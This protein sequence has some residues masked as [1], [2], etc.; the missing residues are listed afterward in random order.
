MDQ[1]GDQAL[2]AR[3]AV[4]V[5]TLTDTPTLPFPTE[6]ACSPIPDPASRSEPA[7][8]A[9]PPVENHWSLPPS[10][11]AQEDPDTRIL[12]LL[13]VAMKPVQAS[14]EVISSRITAI[15]KDRAW[16]PSCNYTS[17]DHLLAPPT[18]WAGR[19]DEFPNYSPSPTARD[20]DTPMSDAGDGWDDSVNASRMKTPTPLRWLNAPTR[21]TPSS[22]SSSARFMTCHPPHTRRL[23][24]SAPNLTRS[25]G[26]SPA[27]SPTCGPTSA[28]ART[29]PTPFL[30]RTTSTSSAHAPGRRGH[31]ASQCY[32]PPS[33]I[34]CPIC[35]GGHREEEYDAKCPNVSK[36]IGI[37]CTCPHVCINCVQAK[38]PTAKGHC[39]S[40][41]SFGQIRSHSHF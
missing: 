33:V 24:I 3:L 21:P 1:S 23:T 35:G 38:K 34:V 20:E 16:D 25:S 2:P 29:S 5:S 22:P 10:S 27:S 12:R 14:I 11:V 39:T 36:H 18:G 9:L 4:G 32:S 13:Q 26:L 37:A 31:T 15:E 19:E 30:P 7:S 41:A 40:S 6:V 28:T 8:A 17:D